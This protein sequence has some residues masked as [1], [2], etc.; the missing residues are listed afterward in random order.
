MA[1]KKTNISELEQQC[2]EAKKNLE[3]LQKQFEIAKKEEEEKKRAKLEAEKQKRYEEVIDAY[4]KFVSLKT[5]Y[6]NDYGYLYLKHA[7]WF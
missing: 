3:V 2:L 7:V 5:A 6:I 1:T 4:D